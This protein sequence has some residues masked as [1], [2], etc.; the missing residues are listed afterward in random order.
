[1]SDLTPEAIADAIYD[2]IR[3]NHGKKQ[4]KPIDIGK[5]VGRILGEDLSRKETKGALKVLMA[6][7]RCTYSYAGK[8]AVVLNPTHEANKDLFE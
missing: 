6:S 5:E 1:M 3:E 4:F 7:G 2:M 8:S